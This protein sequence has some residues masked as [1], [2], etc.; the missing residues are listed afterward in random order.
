MFL[1]RGVS[2][3]SKKSRRRLFLQ[4]NDLKSLFYH[5]CLKKLIKD[6]IDMKILN[7]WI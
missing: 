6:V 1:L 5:I 4:K 3:C 7:Y 2:A